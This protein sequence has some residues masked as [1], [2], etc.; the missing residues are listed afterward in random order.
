MSAIYIA[1]EPQFV[2]QTISLHVKILS[3]CDRD[4]H[5]DVV[6]QKL[7][8]PQISIRLSN[9]AICKSLKS[10]SSRIIYKR[11]HEKIRIAHIRTLE[12]TIYHILRYYN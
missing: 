7:L 5:L 12:N 1:P 11:L 4:L 8:S 10:R 3:M 2:Y 6:Q 9:S